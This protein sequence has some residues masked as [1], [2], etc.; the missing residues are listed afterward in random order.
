VLKAIL[1]T[2]LLS[3][4]LGP[5][6]APELPT[7]DH[8]ATTGEVH[9]SSPTIVDV[10]GDGSNE[11]VVADL[12]GYVYV[13]SAN[14]SELDG[15]PQ[16]IRI[17]GTN[18]TAVES[19]PTV[20][21]LDG[22]GRNEIIVGAGSRWVEHQ[23]GGV[24]I[25]R[26]D[27]S[28]RCRYRTEDLF[29]VWDDDAGATPDG[30]TE[31]V[32]STPAI[33]DIDGDGQRDVV[34]GA[35]D[36]HVHA[37]DSHCHPIP[38]FP[39]HVDD[40][41]WSSP[42]L[43][44]IDGD[45]NDEI[46]IGSAA[47][48]GGPENWKGGVFRSLDWTPFMGGYVVVRWRQ[49]IGEVIDS[50]PAIGDIDGDGRAE[51][52]VGTGVFYSLQ[53]AV[54]DALHV[55]AWHL[56]DGSPVDGWPVA[57]ASQVWGSPALGDLDGDGVD[58]VV[59]GGRDGFVR[60]F[61]G[62][63]DQL[64]RV[65]PNTRY[66][67]GGEMISSPI[68]ADLDGD[69]A[70]DV[71]LGNGWGTFF[72]R[73]SDGARLYESAGKG[74]AFQNAPAVGRM[75]D[76]Q[77][78][79]ALAGLDINTETGAAWTLAI[80]A[81][82]SRPW[83]Q[84]RRDDRH[85]GARIE[86]SVASSAPKP[87]TQ[88]TCGPDTNPPAIPDRSGGLGFWATATNGRVVAVSAK[89]LGSTVGLRLNAPIVDLA[90]T[91]TGDGYWQLGYDGGLYSF[92]DARFY[93]STGGLPLRSPVIGIASTRDGHGYWLVAA[94]GGVF[95][96]GDAPF[97]GSTGDVR[98]RRP[99][100]ALAPSPSG[101]GYFLFA[102]DGGV[103]TYGD[104]IFQGSA[105]GTPHAPIVDAAANPDG[106]GYWMLAAD[107]SVYSFGEARWYGGIPGKSLCTPTGGSAIEAT[108]TGLGYWILGRDGRVFAFGDARDYGD[109]TTL[110]ATP[111]AV[112]R[113]D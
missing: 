108:S 50:S 111:V 2:L 71:A 6:H 106:L 89:H 113:R 55:F 95:T 26:A 20:A 10:D 14:G 58:D 52:V 43:H 33:G 13:R 104:A 41:V 87:A 8:F 45:G 76:G 49:R 23:N 101:N 81:P 60:A 47:S 34:F 25:L 48:P 80:P 32:M 112:A 72:L 59:F 16:R 82:R 37:I 24:E 54:P 107:G 65:Q 93:G 56:D 27:G 30:Y 38:G 97:F 102:D 5:S 28:V 39:F 92:G 1:T 61:R 11:L 62:N 70:N 74:Y 105:A 103:F 4:P 68:I 83:A 100:V 44:D 3:L 77:W 88:G 67:G 51:A 42:A 21:D 79:V 63:G 99:I 75:D 19:T 29:N 40:S 36:N 22:D 110:A 7:V 64:W 9:H 73:G 109:A 85:S 17:D 15:W 94:D 78:V 12:A 91:P 18:P 57:T 96:Y 46:F 86:R 35:W 84:W 66:E 31:G 53:A 98:L 69:G 90:S